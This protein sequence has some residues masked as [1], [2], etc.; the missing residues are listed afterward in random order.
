M[1]KFD[2][3]KYIKKNYIKDE[4]NAIIHLKIKNKED[5]YNSFDP[6]K[7]K[8]NEAIL[9]YI[10]EEAN[11]IPLNYKITIEIE[12]VPLK[13]KEKE[14]IIEVLKDNYGLNLH[15]AKLN[16]KANYM[17]ILWLSLLGLLIMVY[18]YYYYLDF[19]PW[20]EILDIVGWV[21]WWEAIDIFLF[22]NSKKK[23]EKLNI[24][25]LYNAQVIFK[26]NE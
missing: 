11:Y 5:F 1:K 15:A 26:T 22:E 21:S 13:E 19:N 16:I 9:K 14:H 3:Y 17:K 12:T 18:Y 23:T 6:E 10:E 4:T 7:L 25:Q 20:I 2:V 8:I 24:E